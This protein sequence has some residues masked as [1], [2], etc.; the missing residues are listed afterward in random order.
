MA[1]PMNPP[2]RKS[3]IINR[4]CPHR[5]TSVNNGAHRIQTRDPNHPAPPIPIISVYWCPFV[6]G[7]C[8]PLQ[9]SVHLPRKM[10]T[11]R[12]P[13]FIL[14]LLLALPAFA[15]LAQ[16]RDWENEHVLHIN[17]QPPRAT[18]IPFATT[19]QALNSD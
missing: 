15:A 2:A 8:F 18:F 4:K 17:T 16:P 19:D 1:A 3:H 10:F 9:K 13:L 7:N 12:H 14:S 11:R 6:V 5:L